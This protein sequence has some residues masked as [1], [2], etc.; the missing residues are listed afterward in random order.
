MAEPIT[1]QNINTPSNE[2]A[3]RGF[4]AA[5][6]GFNSALDKLGGILKGAQDAQQF[7][8]DQ[9]EEAKVL[10][11]KEAMG[12]ARSPAEVAS[13]QSQWDTMRA[14]MSNKGR[15]AVLGAEDA[16][17]AAVQ[18][19]MTVGNAFDDAQA[20]NEH[21]VVIG[22]YKAL[23]AQGRG[24][25]AEAMI[26]PYM[27]KIPGFGDIAIKAVQANQ[28]TQKFKDDLLS[29]SVRRTNDTSNAAATTSNAASSAISAQTGIANSATNARQVD[30]SLL[31]RAAAMR[32]ATAEK[33]GATNKG[34]IGSTEGFNAVIDRV[35][36]SV[37]KDLLP[38]VT[39]YVA[40]AIS[41]NPEFRNLPVDV[42]ESIVLKH[43]N[44]IGS[45]YNPLKWGSSSDISKDLGAALKNPIVEKQMNGAMTS[46]QNLTTQLAQ[47]ELIMDESQRRVFPELQGRI[48]A[49]M[50][51][52]QAAPNAS[53]TRADVVAALQG[54]TAQTAQVAPVAK[55]VLDPVAVKAAVDRQ[56]AADLAAMSPAM[57]QHVTSVANL[58]KKANEAM[59]A[60]AVKV[61]E[62]TQVAQELLKK[63]DPSALADFQAGSQFGLLDRETRMAVHEVINGRAPKK[64]K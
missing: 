63:G 59:A 28:G 38:K 57:R 53:M 58:N 49:A 60:N 51:S 14:D 41:Q 47:Q 10:A 62:A 6:T 12:K 23:H 20:L 36:K 1:W 64:V 22:Q 40:D 31:E 21:K 30:A 4:A 2:G 61:Q 48:D 37:D 18:Q 54:Q 44:S 16:R 13:L 9:A 52:Q 25:E 43:A 45:I 15:S 26:A 19:Q 34:T 8:T 35:S 11:F 17:T 55:T 29:S 24:N 3:A 46:R 32:A 50:A 27:D 33:L 5:G 39:Q 42:V 56:Q 7:R